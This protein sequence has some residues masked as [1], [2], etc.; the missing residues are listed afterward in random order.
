MTALTATVAEARNSF[1]RIAEQ[2]NESG[3]EMGVHEPAAVDV[4]EVR[5][6]RPQA[7]RV[8]HRI[9]VYCR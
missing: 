2:V 4:R 9:V 5:P 1:S 6:R 3:R 8:M 7:R